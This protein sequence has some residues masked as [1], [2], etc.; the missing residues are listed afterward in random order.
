MGRGRRINPDSKAYGRE[1]VFLGHLPRT[2]SARFIAKKILLKGYVYYDWVQMLGK[3][4][5][6]PDR[7]KTIPNY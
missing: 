4:R 3:T 2:K 7:H 1:L 5:W 6:N